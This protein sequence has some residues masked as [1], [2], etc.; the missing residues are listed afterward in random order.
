MRIE[1]DYINYGEKEFFNAINNK[2]FIPNS[3]T[4][5]NAGTKLKQFSACFVIPVE[6][7]MKKR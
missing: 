3:P 7:D 1:F 4:L 2:E 5:M 6:D